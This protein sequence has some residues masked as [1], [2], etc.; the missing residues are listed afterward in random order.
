MYLTLS[1]L[2]LYYINIY[3][4]VSGQ[5]DYVSNT[6]SIGTVLYIYLEVSGLDDYVSNTISIGTALFEL[7]LSLQTMIK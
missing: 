7:Y 1:V 4:E 2:E 5:D 3:L 6:I